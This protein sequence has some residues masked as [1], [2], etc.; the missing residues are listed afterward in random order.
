MNGLIQK[1][2]N[3]SEIQKLKARC[4]ELTGEWI[5]FHWDCF[6]DLNDYKEYMK[7]IIA[8]YE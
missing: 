8:E 6:K 7:N 1:I 2:K 4:H 3:D 5:P